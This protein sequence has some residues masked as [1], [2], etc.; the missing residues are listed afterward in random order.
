MTILLL[1]AGIALGVAT[2]AGLDA[3]L[4]APLATAAAAVFPGLVGTVLWLS[5]GASTLAT[6]SW[7]IP[8]TAAMAIAVF[9][10]RDPWSFIV[11]AVCIAGLI[12]MIFST[13]AGVEWTRGV[14]GLFRR[15]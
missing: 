4:G 9:L 11:E 6:F 14:A 13:R 10:L 12:V 8:L 1:G 15:G 3:L 7:T 2:G 5:A